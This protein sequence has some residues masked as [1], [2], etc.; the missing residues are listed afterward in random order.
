MCECHPLEIVIH[1][2]VC[3]LLYLV[4]SYIKQGYMWPHGRRGK[5]KASGNTTATVLLFLN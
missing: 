1:V 4:R 3:Y 5:I 2:L